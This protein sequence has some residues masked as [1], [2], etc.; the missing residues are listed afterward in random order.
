MKKIDRSQLASSLVSGGCCKA[1]AD[2]T[3]P[4]NPNPPVNPDPLAGRK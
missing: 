3:N 1:K 4:A 2:N